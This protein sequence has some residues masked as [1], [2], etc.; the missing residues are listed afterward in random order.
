MKNFVLFLLIHSIYLGLATATF[1]SATEFV[2]VKDGLVPTGGMT[3]LGPVF[4]GSVG[5]CAAA[6]V[7]LSA[8]C[9]SFTFQPSTSCQQATFAAVGTCQLM[10]FTVQ[11]EVVLGP[12]TSSQSFYVAEWCDDHNKCMNSGTC[13]M[14]RWPH[15]CQCPHGYGGTYCDV[16]KSRFLC[17]QNVKF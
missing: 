16:G 4:S 3:L 15:F 10:Y 17:K 8:Q 7:K 13:D 11:D 1:S 9:N 12:A 14:T 6:C 5:R 2:L